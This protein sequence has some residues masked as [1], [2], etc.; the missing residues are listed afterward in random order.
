MEGDTGICN[1]DIDAVEIPAKQ[2]NPV[3]EEQSWL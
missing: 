3:P 1:I 2:H